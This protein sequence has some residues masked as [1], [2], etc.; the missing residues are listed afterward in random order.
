MTKTQENPPTETQEV[1]KFERPILPGLNPVRRP[2]YVP[3]LGGRMREHFDRDQQ[4]IVLRPGRIAGI[5]HAAGQLLDK[6]LVS[7]RLLR[8]MF[9]NRWLR[10][11]KP[12]EESTKPVVKQPE[13]KVSTK[14]Q[15]VNPKLEARPTAI[16]ELLVNTSKAIAADEASLAKAATVPLN[17]EE[18]LPFDVVTTKPNFDAMMAADLRHWLAQHGILP[19]T[20]ITGPRLLVL[21]E[22]KWLELSGEAS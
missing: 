16:S 5:H 20:R 8:Q 4:F 1:V 12:E 18:E 7:T 14:P 2:R 17:V 19:G 11:A 9:D 15:V 21:A 10:L 6:S 22:A 13:P 3:P